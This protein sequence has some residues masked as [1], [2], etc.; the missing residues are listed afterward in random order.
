MTSSSCAVVFV[1]AI[2]HCW[3]GEDA[4]ICS[5]TQHIFENVTVFSNLELTE[6]T[7]ID[8]E[9]HYFYVSIKNLSVNE[10]LYRKVFGCICL[11]YPPDN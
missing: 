1:A 2:S 11:C 7:D 9:S 5:F 8:C 10:Y 6:K 3:S 4:G